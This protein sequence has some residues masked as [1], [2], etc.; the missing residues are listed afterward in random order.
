MP[1]HVPGFTAAG[2]P[3]QSIVNDLGL[4]LAVRELVERDCRYDGPCIVIPCESHGE[5]IRLMRQL[6]SALEAA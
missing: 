5:A 1:R 4:K 3:T 6:R 2:V